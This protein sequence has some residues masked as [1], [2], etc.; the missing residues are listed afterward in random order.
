MGRKP[1]SAGWRNV[2]D[3]AGGV[4]AFELLVDKWTGALTPAPKYGHA[5]YGR[6]IRMTPGEDIAMEKEKDKMSSTAYL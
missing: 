3:R 6:F 4:Y 2:L 5:W 1:C